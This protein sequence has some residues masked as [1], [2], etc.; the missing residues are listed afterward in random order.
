M[1]AALLEDGEEDGEN[2]IDPLIT[3]IR[4]L[5]DDINHNIEIKSRE[6]VR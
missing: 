3:G 1:K 4:T 2:K 6:R 5:F